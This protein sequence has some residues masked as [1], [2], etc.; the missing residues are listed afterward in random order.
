[1]KIRESSQIKRGAYWRVNYRYLFFIFK[2]ARALNRK[3]AELRRWWLINKSA[4]QAGNLII[5]Q[6]RIWKFN[7]NWD[8]IRS[9]FTMTCSFRWKI[10]YH[11][12]I[13]YVTSRLQKSYRKAQR[14]MTIFKLVYSASAIISMLNAK[15]VC[16]LE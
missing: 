9:S 16:L 13:A 15:L 7:P 2:S 8:S 5:T 11:S 3:N 6:K 1:M 4:C 10:S 14:H 12:F